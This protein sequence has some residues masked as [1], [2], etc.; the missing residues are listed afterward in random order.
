MFLPE[1][2][3]PLL[4]V[5]EWRFRSGIGFVRQH[6]I[7]AIGRYCFEYNW[8]RWLSWVRSC[9]FCSSAGALR[10]PFES[11]NSSRA[12][13]VQWRLRVWQSARFLGL[14]GPGLG[15][16][17]VETIEAGGCNPF[18][19]QD[20]APDYP[21]ASFWSFLDAR[22]AWPRHAML[23]CDGHGGNSSPQPRASLYY[24]AIP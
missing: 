23:M 20:V 12:E 4:H 8:L 5:L 15:S 10:M 11:Q 6:R 18:R 21:L 1:R 17:F 19:R 13:F 3:W 2:G 24:R 7:E 9:A 14:D 22:S 16:F